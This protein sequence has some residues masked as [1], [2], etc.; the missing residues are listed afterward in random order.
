MTELKLRCLS[1]VTGF[2]EG[3]VYPVKGF[4]ANNVVGKIFVDV[5]D[6]NNNLRD[7]IPANREHHKSKKI[8]PVFRVL[9]M[10]KFED[11]D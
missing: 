7:I 2:T 1:T 6:D 9:I 11:A 4:I 5:I 8:K 10:P 3:R